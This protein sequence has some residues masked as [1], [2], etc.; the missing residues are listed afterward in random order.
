MF[1]FVSGSL[2]AF[3]LLLVDCFGIGARRDMLIKSFRLSLP[4]K[5]FQCLAPQMNL[6]QIH[7][8][9]WM[10]AGIQKLKLHLA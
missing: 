10:V 2:V 3:G 6:R 7:F 8:L 5:L 1:G 9:G 4:K